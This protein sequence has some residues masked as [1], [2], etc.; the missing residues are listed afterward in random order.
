MAFAASPDSTLD[1]RTRIAQKRVQLE[2][3]IAR[4]LPRKRRLLNLTIIAGTVAAALTAGPAAGGATF[5]AWLTKTLGLTSPSWQLLCGLASLSS[6]TATVT[7]QILK[8]QHTEEYLARAQSCRAKLEALEIGLST[9]ELD[10]PRAAGEFTRCVEEASFLE[11][12]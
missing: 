6:V 2:A 1:L 7:T 12:V 10:T 8:S 9:G 4:A 3:F 11:G 5:T